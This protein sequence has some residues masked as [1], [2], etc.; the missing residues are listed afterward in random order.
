LRPALRSHSPWLAALACAV[1]LG[2][3]PVST[4]SA[5]TRSLSYSAWEIVPGGARV[6]VRVSQL[7][8]SRLGIAFA[9][10]TGGSDPIGDYL[11]RQLRLRAGGQP[12]APG[13][14]IALEAPEG[15]AV[16]SWSYRCPSAGP[17][18]VESAILLDAAPSHL[19]FARLRTPD[20][21]IED[22]VLSEAD[23]RWEWPTAGVER[24]ATDAGSSLGDYLLL[25]VEHIL[26]GW[27]HLA[28]VA[29]LLLLATTFGEVAALVTSFTLAHSVTLALATLGLVRPD[30][31]AVEALIGF[32]IALVAAENGW[33]L[34]GR[35]RGVPVAVTAGVAGLALVPGVALPTA[36][37][38]GVAL[39][40]LCHF[41]LLL[42]SPDPARLRVAVAFVF[43]LVHGFGFA[44]VLAELELPTQRLAVALFGFNAGVEVGQLA[45]VACL[46]PCLRA[47]ARPAGG[48]VLALVAETGSAA[49]CG[50][51][52][53]WF[54]TRALA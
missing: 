25:G 35:G 17:L 8:L 14:A 40:S 30:L 7:D 10:P 27:D 13:E 50:L 28:F 45:V 16:R 32:S 4:A 19:H 11:R 29:A 31:R 20:G 24:D 48:R 15:W 46:W 38:L 53:F 42:R 47:L 3:G 36:A 23:P 39:F 41:G 5:H 51:G 2:I 49:I 54:L 6:Q 34:G 1:A 43:G 44:G 22:R 33:I 26:T 37:L 52:I 9:E 21:R 12:C 18:D